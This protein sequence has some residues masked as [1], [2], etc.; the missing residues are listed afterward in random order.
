M[1]ASHR[2]T[3]NNT[4]YCNY[5]LA[6]KKFFDD[7]IVFIKKL[8]KAIDGMPDDEK[9]QY[10]K[11]TNYFRTTTIFYPFIF[12]RMISL[13]LLIN[14]KYK[15]LPYIYPSNSLIH[16]NL[17]RVHRKFYFGGYRA[18][19]DAWERTT[20]SQKNLEENFQ[21]LKLFLNPDSSLFPFK[22][23]N[24]CVNS[25]IKKINVYK[26]DKLLEHLEN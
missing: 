10:F 14:N 25:I 11:E 26:L 12:E 6:S 8:D 17:K 21:K 2:N 13:F 5:W 16:Q 23:L 7:F 24:R 18:R 1:H 22:F 15:V 20:I 9:E 4:V 19:Y 3:I